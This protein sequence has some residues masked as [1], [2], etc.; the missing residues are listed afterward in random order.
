MATRFQLYSALLAIRVAS[1]AGNIS[2]TREVV[3]K[4]LNESFKA[5]LLNF[6]VPFLLLDPVS[7]EQNVGVLE[8]KLWVYFLQ[9]QTLCQLL[10][11]PLHP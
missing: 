10:E 1:Y 3:L 4:I 6:E 7:S 5:A 11:V 8:S 2:K 9:E